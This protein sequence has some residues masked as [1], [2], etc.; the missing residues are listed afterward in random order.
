MNGATGR[1]ASRQEANG[2]RWNGRDRT[3]A[4]AVWTQAGANKGEGNKRGGDGGEG[5][6]GEGDGGEGVEGEDDGGESDENEMGWNRRD[7][8]D[9]AAVWTQAGA[10]TEDRNDE[11][12]A[13]AGGSGV[14]VY[15]KMR[16]REQQIDR[17]SEQQIDSSGEGGATTEAAPGWGAPASGR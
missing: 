5:D 12:P 11:V 14:H 3:D 8:T 7:R 10:T 17:V 4:A 15:N 13:M 1:N 16:E 9:A 6:G 2:M